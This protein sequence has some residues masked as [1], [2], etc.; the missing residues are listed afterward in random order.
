MS[1]RDISLQ[2]SYN[3]GE[4]DLIEEFY[5]PCFKNSVRYERAVGFFT[6]EILSVISA[7]LSEFIVN[8]GTMS[9][10]CS[11]RFSEEDIKAIERGYE[12][13]NP[14]IYSALLREINRI[15]D[16]I[17]NDSLNFLSWLISVNRLEIKVALPEN[18]SWDNYGIYHEKI[19]LFYDDEGNAVAFSG[20]NNE[21]L[22]GVTCNYESF[23]VYKS[24]VD[25]DRCNI[26]KEHFKELWEG[27]SCGV[28]IYDF[29]EAVKKKIVEKIVPQERPVIK[30]RALVT[31]KVNT[32]NDPEL[33]LNDLWYF[34]KEAINC[35]K[36]NE[37]NGIFSM[38]TGTGKTKTA[39]GGIIEI[40]KSKKGVLTIIC[41]P[42]N[43]I[44]RQWQTE[45][46]GLNIFKH[47]IIAD[48][49]NANW[50]QEMADKIIDYNEGY[51]N[52]CI[53]FT[54]YNTLSGEKFIK[55]ISKV[56]K[57]S[58]VVA[59]EVHWAGADIFSHG[60]LPIFNY[61][62][63]LS[64]TPVRYMDEEGTD[65]IKV[66][67]EKVVYE[68]SLERALKE[69][70]PVTQ[71]TFLSPYQY[72]PKFVS[73]NDEE[74]IEYRELTAKI[75]RQYA[76]ESKLDKHSARYQRLCEK[77]QAVIINANSKYEMLEDLL[78]SLEPI[79]YLLVYCSPKQIDNAQE[80]LNQ[81][82]IVNHRF[83]GEEGISS[84]KEYA[85]MSER[86]YIISKFES[87][88]YKTLVAMKCL[89]EGVNILRAET[90][91]LMASSGNPKEYIQRRG[92]LLRR[93]PAKQIVKI[94]DLI[95]MPYSVKCKV[96]DISE[97]ELKI[98]KKEFKRYEEFASL[99]NNK[100]EAMNEIFKI[101]EAYDIY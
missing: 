31:S 91:I 8:S 21:T 41:C 18:I 87:G 46:D 7:G 79:K 52:N 81:K 100:L 4:N 25:S 30:A 19:G 10:V 55:I 17:I 42:Q 83:T 36:E 90:A 28:R 32:R 99:A 92:R 40:Q 77:R 9:L 11:P 54:T 56:R 94:Y 65:V 98:L 71:K 72:Y 62:L 1:L 73:L 84:K 47:S 15:P 95:V 22:Y 76:K 74:L 60:L 44:I 69:I 5:I 89:D 53:I 38:A 24:W 49:T 58:L 101:K 97:D 34:Q 48:S 13:R 86:D 2:L 85:N 50:M 80:I 20:S 33:F 75:K 88:D 96:D 29:P 61:R 43:T 35:W 45:I 12:D 78:T 64:A 3:S 16:G 93:H 66:F 70:N 23:D 14:I 6:S 59:D 51:I 82:G 68:F 67:F 63:G 26:K 39:I 57:A 37:F 27:A